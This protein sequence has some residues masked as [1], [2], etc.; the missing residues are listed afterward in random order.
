VLDPRSGGIPL[1]GTSSSLLSIEDESLFRPDIH[2]EASSK[3]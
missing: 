2:F 1:I 3:A